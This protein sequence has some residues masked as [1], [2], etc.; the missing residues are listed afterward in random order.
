MISQLTDVPKTCA[1]FDRFKIKLIRADLGNRSRHRG[2]KAWVHSQTQNKAQWLAAC[3][4]VSASS[5]SLRFIL[6]LKIDMISQISDM[7]KTCT[8]FDRFKIKRIWAD[9]GIRSRSEID[10]ISQLSDMPKTC[11]ALDRLKTDSVSAV[12]VHHEISPRLIYNPKWKHHPNKY[13]K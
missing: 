9:F 6:S 12:G 4:H 7:P 1:A 11:A 2:Y 10:M 13:W 8:S 3:G 5:Q